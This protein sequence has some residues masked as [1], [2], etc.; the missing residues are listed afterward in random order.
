VET[1]STPMYGMSSYGEPAG[2]PV[3]ITSDC[4]CQ[5]GLGPFGPSVGTIWVLIRVASAIKATILT[6]LAKYCA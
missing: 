3:F 5:N 2:S 4:C 1:K 6:P